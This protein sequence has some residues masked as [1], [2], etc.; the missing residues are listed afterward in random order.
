MGFNIF[1]FKIIFKLSNVLHRD[2]M[3]TSSWCGAGKD[4]RGK[5]PCLLRCNTW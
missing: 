5:M 4:G 3:V 2:A 1:C